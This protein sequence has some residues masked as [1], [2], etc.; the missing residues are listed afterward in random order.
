MGKGG[1]VFVF[2]MGDP[3]KIVDLATKMI[4]Q[5]GL[6]LEQILILSLLD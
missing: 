5:T 1:E 2:D 3:V 4:T 6:K